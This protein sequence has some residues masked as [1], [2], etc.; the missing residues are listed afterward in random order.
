MVFTLSCP[1]S[2]SAQ[3]DRLAVIMVGLPASGKSFTS[4]NLSRYLRWLGVD[5]Y[6]FSAA[7]YR[8]QMI[9][10][11]ISADFFDASNQGCL[12]KRT[13]VADSTLSDM[14]KWF[15]SDGKTDKVAIM[16][17]SNTIYE[18]RRIIRETLN[19]HGVT[20]IFV[21]CIYEN[22][23]LITEY[24]QFL[25]LL[26]PDYEH[27]TSEQAQ[28]DYKRRIQFYQVNYEPV[29]ERDMSFVKIYNGGQRL[30]INNVFGFIPSKILFYL[31]NMHCGVKKIY[32]R[33]LSC[34][35]EEAISSTKALDANENL[36]VWLSP[37]ASSQSSSSF[38]QIKSLLTALNMADLEGM[39]DDQ[40]S[41]LYP[42]EFRKYKQRPFSYR[43]P[44][45]ESYAD[46]SRRMEPIIMELERLGS[47]VLIVADISVIRCIYSYY[48]ETSNL[49]VKR[50]G[51]MMNFKLFRKFQI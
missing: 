26:S 6:T 7:I 49:N 32:L 13:L 23:G 8:Q 2:P 33:S 37:E 4:R 10:T 38:V 45:C 31:M 39:S 35:V 1:S 11:Q 44:R 47:S 15:N 18:R 43:L 27:M 17:A 16:D 9:G 14:V 51:C 5:T 30:V 48:V 41:S 40:L 28:A 25:H 36:Q 22:E 3:G 29:A 20:T 21:E 34:D 12:E 19:E 24:S 46:L 42:E 50:N